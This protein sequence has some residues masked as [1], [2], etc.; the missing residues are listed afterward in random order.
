MQTFKEFYI[1]EGKLGKAI[2]MGT[3]AASSVFGNFVDDWSKYYQTT[4]NPAKEARATKVLD[5]GY[6]V[7]SDAKKAIDVAIYIFAGD[8]GKDA[9]LLKDYLEKTGAVESGYRTK[10]QYGGGP[11]RSY[12]QVEPETAMDLVKNSSAYFGKKF[13]RVFGDDALKRMQGWDKQTW[14]KMLEKYDSLGAAMAAAKW[15]ATSW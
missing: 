4:N 1:E 10:V 13:H 5:A 9:F 6:T 3:L 7:P 12:W 15:L 2:V 8:E 14:S 11:A